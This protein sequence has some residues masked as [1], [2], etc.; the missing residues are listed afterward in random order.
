[1]DI[2]TF[3]P[4]LNQE[5]NSFEELAYL[6]QKW[7]IDFRQLNNES[8]KSRIFQAKTNNMLISNARLGCHTEQRGSTPFGMRT[9]AVLD[10][11][12]PDFYW[13]GHTVTKNDLLIFPSHG[14]IACFTPTGFGVSTISLS[15]DLLGEFFEHNNFSDFEKIIGKD[16]IVLTTSPDHLNQLRF[17]LNKIQKKLLIHNQPSVYKEQSFNSFTISNDIQNQI[18]LSLLNILIGSANKPQKFH[19]NSHQKSIKTLETLIDYID[20]N[21]NESLK[22]SELCSI[23]KISERTL[24]YIFKRE[25]GMTPKAYLKGQKLY[26]VHKTLWSATPSTVEIRDIANQF[27]FWHM[28]QFATDYFKLFGELP[29]ATLKHSL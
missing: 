10:I 15:N 14:E 22:V 3:T 21:I 12:C 20:L 6:T 18:L 16:E 23:A 26:Q 17:A 28:G 5:F 8:F 24:Q 9:F 2:A 11:D 4:I 25:I 29:S 27:G 7:N 1:M 19:S 13:F